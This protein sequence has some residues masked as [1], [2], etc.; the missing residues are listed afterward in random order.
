[1]KVVVMRFTRHLVAAGFSWKS[2]EYQPLLGDQRLQVAVNRRDTQTGYQLSRR[3]EHFLCA[4][5][6]IR[7][8]KNAANRGPLFGF[9]VHP[10]DSLLIMNYHYHV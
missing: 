8:H 4:Q 3:G 2:D 6:P 10:S 9:S 1:M 5:R 7:L